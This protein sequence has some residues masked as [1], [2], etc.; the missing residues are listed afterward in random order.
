MKWYYPCVCGCLR[1]KKKIEVFIEEEAR[2]IDIEDIPAS[3]LLGITK[4][5]SSKASVLSEKRNELL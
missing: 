5:Q 4:K 2:S 3:P 1:R